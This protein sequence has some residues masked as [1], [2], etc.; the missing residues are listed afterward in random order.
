MHYMSTLW[1]VSTNFPKTY[2]PL[3]KPKCQKSNIKK[4]ITWN[5]GIA[6]VLQHT[7]FEN[8]VSMSVTSPRAAMTSI[9]GEKYKHDIVSVSKSTAWYQNYVHI[10]ACL[11]TE[12]CNA[13]KERNSLTSGLCVEFWNCKLITA[14]LCNLYL[15]VRMV[16]ILHLQLIYVWLSKLHA[17]ATGRLY[18]ET[19]LRKSTFLLCLH[20]LFLIILSKPKSSELRVSWTGAPAC[21]T[22]GQC[23]FDPTY[24]LKRHKNH[25]ALDRDSKWALY[26]RFSCSYQVSGVWYICNSRLQRK[27]F[28]IILLV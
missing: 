5:F 16:E 2:Q 23:P 26:P 7:W 13:W 4:F 1:L 6:W 3:Q 20:M 9:A 25:S 22:E 10:K 24:D 19:F 11:A 14:I 28:G 15:Y 21:R 8:T 27:W 18:H 12:Y 17:L